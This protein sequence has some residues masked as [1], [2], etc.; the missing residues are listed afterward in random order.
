M[1]VA[2]TSGVPLTSFCAPMI[3][4]SLIETDF[5]K[6]AFSFFFLKLNLTYCFKRLEET[7]FFV[8]VI[9]V[10]PVMV[11][12]SNADKTSIVFS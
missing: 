7:I 2:G 4:I 9:P 3:S 6:V 11:N 12:V 5:A 1:P 8:I 10:P